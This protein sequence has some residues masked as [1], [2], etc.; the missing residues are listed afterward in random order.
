[1]PHPISRGKKLSRTV[2]SLWG[3]FNLRATVLHSSSSSRDH[4]VMQSI[5]CS[6]TCQFD[7]GSVVSKKNVLSTLN[8]IHLQWSA[9]SHKVP[10]TSLWDARSVSQLSGQNST[11]AHEIKRRPPQVIEI[12]SAHRSNSWIRGTLTHES[13]LKEEWLH[14][15]HS[16]AWRHRRGLAV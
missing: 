7:T 2:T 3:V 10:V 6:L 15:E 9:V 14:K 4:A 12:L 13:L 8:K 5:S 1:M 11:V 16:K